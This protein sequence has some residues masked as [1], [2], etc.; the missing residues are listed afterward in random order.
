[1]K[2]VF[3][4]LGLALPEELTN[5]IAKIKPETQAEVT[6]MLLKIKGSEVQMPEIKLLFEK[7]GYDLPDAIVKN[8]SERE[9]TVQ[10]STWIY[11]QNTKWT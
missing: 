10:K 6:K 1:M 9:V 3:K 5:A 8:F 11:C 4:S 7:I 2:N